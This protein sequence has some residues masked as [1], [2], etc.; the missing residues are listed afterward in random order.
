MPPPNPNM[1]HECLRTPFGLLSSSA[2]TFIAGSIDRPAAISRATVRSVSPPM[3]LL[4]FLFQVPHSLSL[5]LP[6]APRF[7]PPPKTADPCLEYLHPW[8]NWV[9]R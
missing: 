3:Y 9:R 7:S 2:C 5:R 1:H 6:V 4:H 8:T